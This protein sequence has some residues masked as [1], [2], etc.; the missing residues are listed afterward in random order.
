MRWRLIIE[1][2][3]PELVYIQGETNIVADALSRLDIIDDVDYNLSDTQNLDT[4]YA[5]LFDLS[6]N[7]IVNPLTYK[8]IYG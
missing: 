1:E 5:D 4:F 6:D 7:S 8:Y 3:S 2:F